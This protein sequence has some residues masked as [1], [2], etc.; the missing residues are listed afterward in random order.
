MAAQLVY[1]LIM[2]SLEAIAVLDSFKIDHTYIGREQYFDHEKPS[3]KCTVLIL[4][5]ANKFVSGPR[6][7]LHCSQSSSSSMNNQYD[8]DFRKTSSFILLWGLNYHLNCGDSFSE[9]EIF[10]PKQSYSL[11]IKSDKKCLAVELA[12]FKIFLD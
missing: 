5:N 9:L 4:F 12:C 10:C 7:V 3:A 11:V 1:L 8:D 6:Y 2:L